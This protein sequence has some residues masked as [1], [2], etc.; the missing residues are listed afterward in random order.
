MIKFLLIFFIVI[1]VLGYL[2]KLFLRNWL[3]KMANHGQPNPENTKRREGDI[4]INKK[5]GKDKKFDKSDG[6]YV[7]YE[8]VE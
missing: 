4:H 3:N 7:D 8:E 5:Q 2:G 1:Y 6:E